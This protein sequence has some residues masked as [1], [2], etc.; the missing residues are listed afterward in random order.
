MIR[1]TND[2]VIRAREAELHAGNPC[3]D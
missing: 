3:A 1:T 2:D